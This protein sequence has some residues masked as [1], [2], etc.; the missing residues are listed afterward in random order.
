MREEKKFVAGVKFNQRSNRLALASVSLPALIGKNALDKVFLQNW[1]I[2]PAFLFHREQRELSH[3]GCCKESTAST[4]GN[5]FKIINSYALHA[6]AWGVSLKNITGKIQAR[7]CGDA[8]VGVVAHGERPI[9]T[10]AFSD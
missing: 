10:R 5:T 9:L 8:P 1:V 3:Y 7:Q 4:A 6:A 2:Q